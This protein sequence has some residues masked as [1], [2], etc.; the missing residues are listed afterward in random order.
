VCTYYSDTTIS[1]YSHLKYCHGDASKDAPASSDIIH[2]VYSDLSYNK[3]T[4]VQNLFT[5]HSNVDV[6]GTETTDNCLLN[7]L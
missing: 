5:G 3:R 2:N 7:L 6:K 1:W 4:V